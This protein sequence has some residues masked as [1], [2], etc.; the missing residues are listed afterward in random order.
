M[1]EAGS[2]IASYMQLWV[3]AQVLQW[4]VGNLTGRGPWEAIQVAACLAVFFKPQRWLCAVSLALRMAHVIRRLPA[5]WDSE[6]LEL[7]TDLPIVLALLSRSLPSR[8]VRA[9]LGIFYAAAGLL[10]LN[11]A[12]LNPRYSC[13]TVFGF[14]LLEAWGLEDWTWLSWLV[15]KSLPWTTVVVET[16]VGACIFAGKLRVAAWLGIALHLM[17]A[18]E[19]PPNNIGIYGV[20]CVARYFWLFPFAAADAW[21]RSR[22]FVG[23]V[24]VGCVL[25]A[26]TNYKSNPQSAALDR[27]WAPGVYGVVASVVARATFLTQRPKSEAIVAIVAESNTTLLTVSSALVVL[28][29]AL[30][31][32]VF[33]IIDVASPNM[34]SN[35]AMHGGSNHWFLATGLL[36]VWK[37]HDATSVFGGGV[38]RVDDCN[39]TY[40]NAIHPGDLT[41]ALA[42]GVLRL[43]ERH[44]HSGRFWNP[45]LA[46]VVGPHVMPPPTFDP[47]TVPNYELARLVDAAAKHPTPFRLVYARLP[48]VRGD[49]QWRRHAVERRV[50]LVV[51]GDHRTCTILKPGTNASRCDDP[52]DFLDFSLYADT[53]LN[54]LGRK[55]LLCNSYAQIPRLKLARSTERSHDE[56]HCYSS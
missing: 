41:P 51:A 27:D 7:L 48:G 38:V 50:E 11:T 40:V 47:Y 56:V 2:V 53:L 35:L 36:H 4:F 18:I 25:L 55:L 15:F 31:S 20:N 43:F 29:W 16:G 19:V 42:P 26:V 33:G 46:N 5:V 32:V 49:A 1:S 52:A 12:F 23:H 37:H 21:R 30:G 24:A 22:D 17:I 45:A 6:M 10:K 9:Q 39:S 28:A 34:F 54:R 3:L 14:Q 8:A 13:A 44:R